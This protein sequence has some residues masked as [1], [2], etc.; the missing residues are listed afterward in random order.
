MSKDPSKHVSLTITHL[1]TMSSY[2]DESFSA[3]K[4]YN[5]ASSDAPLLGS[6]CGTKSPPTLTTDGSAMHIDI[7]YNSVLFATYS[8][9][10]NRWYLNIIIFYSDLCISDCGGT[11]TSVEGTFASPGYPKKYSIE[12]EC[13]WTIDIPE[14]NHLSV[15]FTY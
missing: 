15:T 4:I 7:E 2:C 12:T 8:I 10:D 14:G 11:L 3:L 6:Y 13:E 9:F 1:D 5:G